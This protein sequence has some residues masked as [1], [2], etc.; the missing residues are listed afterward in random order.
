MSA[1]PIL[2]HGPG[3]LARQDVRMAMAVSGTN[4]HYRWAQIT[5]RHWTETAKRCGLGADI[6]TMLGELIE[7]T[8]AVVSRVTSELP[9]DFPTNVSDPILR[10]LERAAETL[11]G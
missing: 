9:T 7:Q 2:G 5:R 6:D 4:R 10:G 11:A 8:P 1:Y 3:R